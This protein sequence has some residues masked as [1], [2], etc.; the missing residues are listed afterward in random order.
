MWEFD[1]KQSAGCEERKG[2]TIDPTEEME[3]PNTKSGTA[4]LLVKFPGKPADCVLNYELRTATISG[5]L[6]DILL[7][8]LL[9]C[10]LSTTGNQLHTAQ[11]SELP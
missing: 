9:V 7:R 6:G 3:I 5:A 4:H 2:V 11:E 1:V 10:Y 8:L